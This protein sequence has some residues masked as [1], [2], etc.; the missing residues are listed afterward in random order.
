[1]EYLV[2]IAWLSLWPIVIYLGL[3]ISEKNA[4]KFEEKL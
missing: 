4:M 1:M 2:E 3:K